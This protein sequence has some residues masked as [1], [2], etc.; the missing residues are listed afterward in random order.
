MKSEMAA[1]ATR[2]RGEEQLSGLR[3]ILGDPQGIWAERATRSRGEEQL[4]G[5]RTILGDPQG[6]WA[7]RATRSR[8]EEQLSGLRTICRDPQGRK[9]VPR[10]VQDVCVLPAL[11]LPY[12]T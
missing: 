3:T 10:C 8:L 6:I 12:I 9:R 2:S 7:A 5:L 11:K 1:R 4:S